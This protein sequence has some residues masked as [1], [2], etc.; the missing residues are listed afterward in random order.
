MTGKE[1]LNK[2]HD[3]ERTRR[4]LENIASLFSSSSHGASFSMGLRRREAHSFGTVSFTVTFMPGVASPLVGAPLLFA[5]LLVYSMLTTGSK[6]EKNDVEICLKG[7]LR[8]Q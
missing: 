4:P 7:L 1:P 3:L 5:S 6:E 2:C 8:E